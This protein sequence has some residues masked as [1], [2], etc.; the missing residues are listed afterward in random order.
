[1]ISSDS[2]VDGHSDKPQKEVRSKA[3]MVVNGEAEDDRNEDVVMNDGSNGEVKEGIKN[4][5]D[6]ATPTPTPTPEPVATPAPVKT[7]VRKGSR[8]RGNEVNGKRKEGVSG[9]E[10]GKVGKR[11]KL[12]S[13]K[14]SEYIR[15]SK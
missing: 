11:R 7:P 8:E 14:S 12:R 6:H 10:A 13:S 3:S 2:S 15:I 1:M 5:T 4:G 9:T